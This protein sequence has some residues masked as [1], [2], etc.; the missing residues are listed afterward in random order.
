MCDACHETPDGQG[1]RCNRPDGFTPQEGDRRN[2]SRNMG[3]ARQ[4]LSDGDPQAAANSLARALAAQQSLDGGPSAPVQ[5]PAE[6]SGMHRDFAVSPSDL[7]TALSHIEQENV[8]R[9]KVGL[10]RMEADV[11]RQRQNDPNDPIMA[12]ERATVRVSNASEDDLNRLNLGNV[13]DTP[14]RKVRTHAVLEAAA[15]STRLNGGVYTPRSEGENS[16]PAQVNAYVS[17]SPNG[18]HRTRLAPTEEDKKTAVNVRM[19]ARSRQP[20]SDYLV[21]LRHSMSEEYMS[22]REAGTASSAISGFQRY[23]EQLDQN[24]A[25]ST[26]PSQAAA[27]AAGGSRWLSSPGDKVTVPAH[28]VH[29]QP[30]YDPEHPERVKHLYVMRT[31]DGDLVRWMASSDKYLRE[32][33]DV[34]L[35][36]TVKA[37][38]THDGERQTE[39]FYC[40][41]PALHP[42]QAAAQG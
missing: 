38:S 29:A 5:A 20:T 23:R 14:E 30:Q 16:V 22:P 15:A 1:R 19:W 27:P 13:R 9:E 25:Q 35:Q 32:G 3:N 34:T 41:P 10:P 4:A 26:A 33:D 39:I 2:R 31:P 11:S 17:D 21:A 12:Y 40:K 8:A 7:P 6:N 18:P 37:H 24:K 36:G 28:I 42:K